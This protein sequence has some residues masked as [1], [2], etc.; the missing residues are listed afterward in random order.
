M[1]IHINHL[2]LF[3]AAAV[4]VSKMETP[5]SWADWRHFVEIAAILSGAASG[6]VAWCVHKLHKPVTEIKESLQSHLVLSHASFNRI[7][8]D[9]GALQREHEKIGETLA[10]HSEKLSALNERTEMLMRRE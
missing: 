8:V 2:G 4:G 10:Q 1:E 7:E 6:A 9:L 3:L 5:G